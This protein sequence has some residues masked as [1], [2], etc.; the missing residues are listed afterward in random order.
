[1]TVDE[2]RLRTTLKVYEGQIP[3]AGNYA[4]AAISR[5]RADRRKRIG[6]VGGVLTA[7]LIVGIGWGLEQRV[8]PTGEVA[9]E[10]PGKAIGEELGLEPVA[11]PP[12]GSCTYFAAYGPND[13][14][15]LDGYS[16]DTAELVILTQ[17]INGWV[18]TEDREKYIRTSLKL[19]VLENGSV[20][21]NPGERERL[22]Q[23]LDDSIGG[24]GV[25]NA[26]R[27]LADFE[28]LTGKELG[29]ALGLVP[30]TYGPLPII[31]CNHSIE[32]GKVSG[33]QWGY[34]L[35]GLAEDDV[36]MSYLTTALSGN[37]WRIAVAPDVVGLTE[38]AAVA[39]MEAAGF[40]VDVQRYFSP[41]PEGLVV[42][43]TPRA[44]DDGLLRSPASIFVSKGEKPPQPPG[45]TGVVPDVV[46]MTR[47]DAA[48]AMEDAGFRVSVFSFIPSDQPRGT[49]LSQYPAAGEEFPLGD[50]IRLRIAD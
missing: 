1:M 24:R 42:S 12:P 9:S 4:E 8:T 46:G 31:L 22:E 44:G 27:D 5:A 16:E 45:P 38:D 15:C 21:I 41:E 10:P 32:M 3:E 47:G 20:P 25:L 26:P 29:D 43:Q 34:C 39:A 48:D 37:D 30:M 17:R 50:G 7:L 19:K 28:G 35:E 11:W 33:G 13:G 2:D 18:M 6:V 23:I 49:V 14:Y 36:E 40:A